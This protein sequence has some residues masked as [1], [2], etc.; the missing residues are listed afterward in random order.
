VV[1]R[2]LDPALGI[3][4]AIKLLTEHGA[5]DP[6]VRSR[7]IAAARAL[8]GLS[9]DRIVT[10]HDIGEFEGRPYLVMDLLTDGTL[11]DRLADGRTLDPD[12]IRWLID[13]L[14][15]AIVVVHAAGFVHGDIKPR[16]VLIR[17]VS[18]RDQ[19]VLADFGLADAIEADVDEAPEQ[20]FPGGS[21]DGRTDVY[22]ASGVVG[23]AALGDE[24][25]PILV[26][27]GPYQ[28]TALEPAGTEPLVYELRRGLSADPADRHSS[29]SEWTEAM[30]E[31]IADHA[32][33]AA[34]T[35][36]P[37]AHQPVVRLVAAG[38]VVLALVLAFATVTGT[39]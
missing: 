24:W 18:G 38:M 36:G 17:R 21:I 3:D 12:G 4:V 1:Y 2:A 29:I 23:R 27:S 15:A 20:R 34:E 6:E 30:R 22:A 13:G 28:V 8:R 25:R 16:N 7:F 26:T 33:V 37:T 35:R 14:G 39:P 5:H 32:A 9:D 19:L 31:A 11:Q 10:V